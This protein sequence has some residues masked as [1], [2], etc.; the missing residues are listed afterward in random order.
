MNTVSRTVSGI[1]AFLLGLY[2]IV[3]VLR[4]QPEGFVTV[5]GVG[6][7]ILIAGIG[8]FLFFNKKEDDIEQIKDNQ[9]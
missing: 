6:W 8:V 1:A 2:I 4:E 7:G 9:D 3:S 5:Y